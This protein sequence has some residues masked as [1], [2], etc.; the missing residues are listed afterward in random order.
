MLFLLMSSS[1]YSCLATQSP[2][3]SA[4]FLV[5]MGIP[6]HPPTCTHVEQMRTHTYT[7][8]NLFKKEK[9]MNMGSNWGQF[10]SERK[11]TGQTSCTLLQLS[12]EGTQKRKWESQAFCNVYQR[13]LAKQPHCERRKWYF[14]ER[15]GKSKESQKSKE[16]MCLGR[17]LF[18]TQKKG[19]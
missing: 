17:H 12:K 15:M 2:A 6:Y 7:Q 9:N 8:I 18:S 1:Q 11:T 10:I 14:K 4:L 13:N 3:T 5:S 19:T 16:T